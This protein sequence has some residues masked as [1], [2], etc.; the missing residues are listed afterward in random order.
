MTGGLARTEIDRETG[1]G[2]ESRLALRAR[3]DPD[4]FAALYHRYLDP[5]Y[6]YCYR[7]LET[8]EAA[9]DAASQVFERALKSIHQYRG[10]SF[11]AWLFRIAYTTV[12][13]SYKWRSPTVGDV[14]QDLPDPDPTPEARSIQR[15][16]AENV[17]QLLRHLTEEQARVVELR[18][19][20]LKGPEIAEVMGRK[21]DAVRMLQYRAME[22]LRRHLDNDQSTEA[23]DD[24]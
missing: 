4:A 6:R 5:I 8:P 15:E 16:S 1:A 22:R 14:D 12:V 7:R 13:D 19:A 23:R 3:Q 20:G 10:G 11:R 18:L 24:T 9:E 17:Q 21:T 2:D